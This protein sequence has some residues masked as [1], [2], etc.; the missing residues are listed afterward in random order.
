MASTAKLA[1]KPY[2]AAWLDELDACYELREAWNPALG[3]V[4]EQRVLIHPPVAQHTGRLH[5]LIQSDYS[6][7]VKKSKID[8][9]MESLRASGQRVPLSRSN[10]H[11][12]YFWD[13]IKKWDRW[14]SLLVIKRIDQ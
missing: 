13:I 11:V 12:S 6:P 2:V 9:Y 14:K 8:E 10:F 3:C 7:L 1:L 5:H 4:M